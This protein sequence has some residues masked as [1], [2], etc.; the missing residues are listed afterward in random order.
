MVET[1]ISKILDSLRDNLTGEVDVEKFV[2]RLFFEENNQYVNEFQQAFKRDFFLPVSDN[3]KKLYLKVSD[4]LK[5]SEKELEKFDDKDIENLS[6]PFGLKE[7]KQEYKEK[8]E[9]VKKELNKTLNLKNFEAQNETTDEESFIKGIRS[10]LVGS[11]T[12]PQR[13]NIPLTATDRK[14]GTDLEQRGFNNETIIGFSTRT[15]EFLE[16]LFLNKFLT[17]FFKKFEALEGSNVVTKPRDNNSSLATWGILGGLIADI[18][19]GGRLL[20]QAFTSIKNTILG[21]PGRIME[22][23]KAEGLY[24]FADYKAWFQLRWDQYI[25]D[26]LKAKFPGLERFFNQIGARIDFI[27][28]ETADMYDNFLIKLENLKTS[29]KNFINFDEWI[30]K[31]DEFKIKN[32]GTLEVLS[33]VGKAIYTTIETPIKMIYNLGKG[34]LGAIWDFAKFFFNIGKGIFD[35]IINFTKWALTPILGMKGAISSFIEKIISSSATLKWVAEGFGLIGKALGKLIWFIDPIIGAF[36]GL[37]EVWGDDNLSMLQKG[38][39]IL[40]GFVTGLADIVYWIIDIISKGVTGIWNFFV[41]GGWVTDN[42]VSK[43]IEEKIYQGQGSLSGSATKL[44]ADTM[45]DYNK[46]EGA[47]SKPVEAVITVNGK[48]VSQE[49]FDAMQSDQKTPKATPQ[50]LPA[51]TP[52]ATPEVKVDDFITDKA[53]VIESEGV[54][55]RLNTQQSN[56]DIVSAMK[57]DGGFEKYFKDMINVMVDVRKEITDLKV[58]NI[59]TAKSINNIATSNANVTI[60]NAGSSS[61]SI[62]DYRGKADA[63]STAVPLY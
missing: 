13:T 36:R 46:G 6:D 50:P 48:R 5:R 57:R 52:K 43:W 58:A 33:K 9:N 2:N 23:L 35:D 20:K 37:F 34:T 31:I 62:H 45:R 24:K 29:F 14:S 42:S 47:F 28:W 18:M 61:R 26:P 32:S 25:W 4:K 53:E 63:Y 56:P 11:V 40:T 17:L 21:F 41:K 16:D 59:N 22:A 39:V 19:N 7:L 15:E 38:S 1:D 49:E 55:Y 44:A 8:I 54:R 12:I 30:A 60:N 10:S 3:F 51:P 27:K